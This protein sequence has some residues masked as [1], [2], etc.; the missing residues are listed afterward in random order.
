MNLGIKYLMTT[1]TTENKTKIESRSKGAHFCIFSGPSG[2]P[3]IDIYASREEGPPQSPGFL[4]PGLWPVMPATV[5]HRNCDLYRILPVMSVAVK[6]D[7]CEVRD[8]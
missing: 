3:G 2:P 5:M 7:V 4:Q 1:D 8:R 6:S